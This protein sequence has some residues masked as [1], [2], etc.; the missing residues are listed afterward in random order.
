MDLNK[1]LEWLQRE[2]GMSVRS[3]R[4]VVSR[5]KR[6]AKITKEEEISSETIAALENSNE[7][8][9]ASPFI[10]SQLKRAVVLYTEF[11]VQE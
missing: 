4:D 9:E 3:A 7:Y 10:R 6:V 5:L 11:T 2:Q 1:F 8:A